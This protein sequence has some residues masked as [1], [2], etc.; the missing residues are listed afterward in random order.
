MSTLGELTV[1]V[2]ADLSG[3]TSAFSRARSEIRNFSSNLNDVSSHSQSTLGSVNNLGGG[4]GSLGSSAL[5]SAGMFAAFTAAGAVMKGFE[6]VVSGVEFGLG[7]LKDGISSLISEGI[8]YNANVEDNQAAFE[9]MLGSATKAKNLLKEIGTMAAKTPFETSDLTDASKT[10][11]GFGIA[12]KD[13]IPDL[14]MLGDIALGNK[15]RFKGLALVFAQVQSQGKLMGSDLLQMINN[16]FNPLQA[17]SQKTGKSMSKLKD[18]MSAGKISFDMVR[19]AM[20]SAT[21]KGGLYFGSMDKASAT[22]NGQISTMKDN[23]S[24]F[25]GIVTKPLFDVLSKTALPALAK[26]GGAM[27]DAFQKKG[28]A[29]GLDSLISGVIPKF[30][31]FS[32]IISMAKSAWKNF[33]AG[34]SGNEAGDLTY[35]QQ[36]FQDL[37]TFIRE[38]FTKIKNIKWGEIFEQIKTYAK[39]FLDN[40]TQI[41]ASFQS[42]FTNSKGEISSFMNFMKVAFNILGTQVIPFLSTAIA[43]ILPVVV[44]TFSFLEAAT[45]GMYA[46]LATVFNALAPVF[47]VVF[48]TISSIITGFSSVAISAIKTMTAIISGNWSGAWNGIKNT[49]NNVLAFVSSMMRG[50]L[51]T[52]SSIVSTIASNAYNG[53]R[54]TYNNAVSAI[55]G[56]PGRIGVVFASVASAAYSAISGLPSQAWNWG[57]NIIQGLI[58]GL[59]SKIGA[60]TDVVGGIAST[61]KGFFPNSPAKVGA[62]RTIPSWGRNIM[63]MLG[64]GMLKSFPGVENI[65]DGITKNISDKMNNISAGN[66]SSMSSFAA[67]SNQNINLYLDGKKVAAVTAPHM[68]NY[69][70]RQGV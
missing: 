12:Q 2:N 44:Y 38:T 26:I 25:A 16:G 34:F 39:P 68:V 18:E 5:S 66:L 53:F 55:S 45:K 57:S 37:G 15:D 24:I 11:M 61:I 9:V 20:V 52:I 41:K 70:K 69:I 47:K 21:S 43:K 32:N 48:N 33:I 64:D 31:L 10:L 62:L 67:N 29:G 51:N 14:K 13:V 49:V 65:T 30:N 40:W 50:A 36:V 58:D 7:K 8:K 22:F 35:F 56:L 17:I 46:T 19:D 63:T 27:T 4:M 60:I 42:F 23:F 28:L 3:M 59:R 1:R 54:N 6:L